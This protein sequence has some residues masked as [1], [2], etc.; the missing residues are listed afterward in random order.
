MDCPGAEV[1]RSQEVQGEVAW[2]ADQAREARGL[3]FL[4][5]APL[6]S[7]LLLALNRLH[8]TVLCG[9]RVEIG[10]LRHLYKASESPLPSINKQMKSIFV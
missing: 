8:F 1:S 9:R 2:A 3:L 6:C 4:I 7:P 5:P 10:K